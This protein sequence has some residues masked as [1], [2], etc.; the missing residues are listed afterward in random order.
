MF[1]NLRIV[2]ITTP[3]RDEA[4]RIGSQIV[5]EKL[6]ACANIIDGMESVYRWQ[7][8]IKTDKESILILKTSYENVSRLTKRVKELH[9]YKVPCI[10]SINITE[11]EGNEEYLNWILESV[12]RPISTSNNSDEDG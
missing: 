6:A 12:R 2:Y 3:G 1:R 4:F 11:Q 10:I 8:E 9:S 5:D 7:G